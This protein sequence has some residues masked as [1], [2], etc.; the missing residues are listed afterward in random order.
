MSWLLSRGYPSK[1]SLKIVGDRHRL[2]ERQRLAVSRAACADDSLARRRAHLLAVE[3]VSGRDIIIDGFNLIITLEAA[4][5]GGLLL[6]ARDDCIRDLS[7]VHGSY[8]SVEET[9]KAILLIG[10]A[11]APLEPKSARWLLD[12]PISN[13]G[14]LARK[15]N[16]LATERGWPWSVRVVFNPDAE[17][18]AAGEIA[19]TSDSIILDRVA[20]WINFNEYLVKRYLPESWL[21][22]L[23]V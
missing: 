20:G 3:E 10:K 11:L 13:S 23:R 19:V 9:E 17:I 1:A 16:E 6:L 4:L 8:R 2:D 22:D 12:Q 15:I 5:G 18:I 7:S 14:R 21:V